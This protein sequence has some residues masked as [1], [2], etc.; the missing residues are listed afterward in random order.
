MGSRLC[1]PL[2]EHKYL[3]TGRS[4][5]KCVLSMF[6]FVSPEFSILRFHLCKA[7]LF[8]HEALGFFFRL[9]VLLRLFIF[10]LTNSTHRDKNKDLIRCW[11]VLSDKNSNRYEVRKLVSETS[12]PRE[13]RGGAGIGGKS[14]D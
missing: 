8:I 6:K 4:L 9:F 13:Q 5:P 10:D 7:L 2:W 3:F 14:S 11:S 12:P 1:V